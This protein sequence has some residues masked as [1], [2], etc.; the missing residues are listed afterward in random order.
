MLGFPILYFKSMRLM[1]FQLSGF[2]CNGFGLKASAFKDLYK[3][4]RVLDSACL[5]TVWF[6]V[7]NGGMDYG[8]YYWGFYRDYFWDPFPHSLLRTRES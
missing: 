1:M 7:G 5:S 4:V 3:G 8:D 6:L 2:Y